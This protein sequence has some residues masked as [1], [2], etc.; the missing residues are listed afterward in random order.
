MGS[1]KD[2][3]CPAC[4][5]LILIAGAPD[6]CGACLWESYPEAMENPDRVVRPN[7][8]SLNQA[9]QIAAVAG[10]DKLRTANSGGPPGKKIRRQL[11][12]RTD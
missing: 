5:S 2:K 10:V 12:D 8:V 7:Y 11:L 6:M 1:R 3:Y 9:R 4:N